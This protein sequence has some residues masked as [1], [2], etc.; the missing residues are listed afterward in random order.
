MVNQLYQ[1]I[2]QLNNL[3]ESEEGQELCKEFDH[4]SV[5]DALRNNLSVLRQNIKNESVNGS[6][7]DSR[8]ILEQARK[9]LLQIHEPKL[10]RLINATGVIIHTNLGRAVL[11]REAL[12]AIEDVALNYSNLEFN[13]ANGERGSRYS[14]I[15]ELI[16]NV[17]TAE[18][19]LVVNNCAAAVLLVLST[20]AKNKEVI[21]SRGEL[22]EIGGSFRMPDVIQ[23]SGAKLVEVGSTNKTKISDYE[24]ALSEETSLIL[25]SHTSNY[26][27]VGFTAKPSRS[28]L[29]DLA[30]KNN[31]PFAEDL[32]S[33]ALI[34]LDN[35]DLP[36]EPKI[37]DCIQQGADI[38]MFSGDKLLGGPQAGIIL[39][40]RQYIESMK[41]NP[42][43]RALRIDKLCL[44]ALEA[45]LKLYI[46]PN[47]PF[48]QIPVLKMLNE[49]NANL[50]GR[51]T[52]VASCLNEIDHISV[53]VKEGSS[54][55]GGGSLPSSVLPT[56]L[57]C[58]KSKNCTQNELAKRLREL[59]PAVIGRISDDNLV[60]DMRTVQKDEIND[61]V[62]A[63]KTALQT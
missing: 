37:Q 34:D 26:E 45:T 24:Q 47:I 6:S 7:F 42:L 11:P 48:D 43:L 62:A 60:L 41:K 51:A 50:F 16:T 5:V 46:S 32:G 3:L 25:K 35:F 33:G 13:L 40:S 30:K 58:I 20:F 56:S 29:A 9:H 63:V 27:V 23:Q 22:I 21:V 52:E 38:V 28:E 39:G 49:D 15:E 36:N 54:L 61:V 8:D 59:N 2:P 53:S 14:H 44:A 10:K 1:R 55:I 12:S 57:V 18:S 4:K 17:T 31:I 19:A